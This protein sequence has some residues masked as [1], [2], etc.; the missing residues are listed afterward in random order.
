MTNA[1]MTPVREG[2]E[3]IAS[4]ASSRAPEPTP[5]GGVTPAIVFNPDTRQRVTP[6][7]EFPWKA[8][9][10]LLMKF[11]N[12]QTY[13]GT[14]VLV[15]KQHVL[16]AAHNLFG[17]DIG[18]WATEVWFIPAR[19]GDARPYGSLPAQNIFVTEEYRT[20]SP[21]DPNATPTGTVTDYTQYTEDYGLVRLREPVELPIFGMYAAS[22]QQLRAPARI[23]GYPGDKP[24]GTM[25]TDEKS[26][27]NADDHFLFYKINTYKGQ[28]GA[29][30]IEDLGLP[31][32]KTI[33]GV[34]V[35]GSTKLD[36]NFG[37]RLDEDKL[38]Q[39]RDWMQS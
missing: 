11:P 15:D 33:V 5:A 26:L 17:N 30:I 14:G 6:T 31:V 9:G 19:D 16:T 10:Q 34:H 12:G 18:G 24:A 13:S 23:T 4:D 21:A 39:I 37:V 1:A 29:A 25:W 8:M 22:N 27:N 38:A 32:G 36:I 28:S 3:L 7:T 35:A 2:H 20:L